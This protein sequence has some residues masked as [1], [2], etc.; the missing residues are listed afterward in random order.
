MTVPPAFL[1]NFPLSLAMRTP[2]FP[3]N[4]L[5]CTCF[6]N[7]LGGFGGTGVQGV[8]FVCGGW[9]GEVVCWALAAI[10]ANRTAVKMRLILFVMLPPEKLLTWQL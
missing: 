5:M 9:A 6:C 1:L 3:P 4:G 8:A 10:A 7:S 2:I